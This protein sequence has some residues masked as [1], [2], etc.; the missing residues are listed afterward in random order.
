MNFT[1]KLA[2]E[3]K[4]HL[5]NLREAHDRRVDRA[6]AKA[7]RELAV[8][9]TRTEKE[10]IKLQLQRDK[11]DAKKELYEAQVA[12]Q[13][14]KKALEVARKE[15]GDLTLGERLSRAGRSFGRSAK[16]T[17]AALAAQPKRRTPRR[18]P[19][20]KKAKKE[21]RTYKRLT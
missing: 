18:K 8:A 12:T 10:K 3:V 21:R 5:A 16:S 13:K 15:A 1:Q 20:K 11:M 7:R 2:A 17:W 4:K 6:T 19:A 9:K 14:A